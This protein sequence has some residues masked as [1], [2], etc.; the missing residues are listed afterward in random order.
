[1]ESAPLVIY[2]G[3]DPFYAPLRED[4]RFAALL[5]RPGPAAP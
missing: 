4:P 5:R 3:V 2:Q 1:V